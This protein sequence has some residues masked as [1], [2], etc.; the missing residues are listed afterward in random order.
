M[1]LRKGAARRCCWGLTFLQRLLKS[2]QPSM[3]RVWL[4]LMLLSLFV[5]LPWQW[6][7]PCCSWTMLYAHGMWIRPKGH[8]G[9][10]LVWRSNRSILVDPTPEEEEAAL[11]CHV[12]AFAFSG[13]DAMAPENTDESVAQLVYNKSAGNTS[14]GQ[15]KQLF[16]TAEDS[17]RDTLAH[18]RR[19]LQE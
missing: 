9:A 7:A 14:M 13:Y 6:R 18:L 3:R 1:R 15:W 17:A 4:L 5:Q 16:S 11:S 12:F 19:S 2:P 8:N 10:F